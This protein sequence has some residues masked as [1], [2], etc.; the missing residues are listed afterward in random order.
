ML[1]FTAARAEGQAYCAAIRSLLALADAE[2]VQ[3]EIS[4][5]LAEAGYAED[6]AYFSKGAE[7]LNRVLDEAEMLTRGVR[8]SAEEFSSLLS[9][10]LKSLEISLIPQFTDAVFVGSLSESK[11]SAGKVL[12]AAALTSDVPASGAD[13]ALISDRDIDRLRTLKVEIQPKIR[14]VNARARE[15]AALALCSFTERLY[16]T[17]PLSQGGKECKKSEI[18][19]TVFAALAKKG[20]RAR[21]YVYA[22]QIRALGTGKRRRLRALS[23]VCRHRAGTRA[24]RTFAARRSIQAGRGGVLRAQRTV[25]RAEK[26]RRGRRFSFERADERGF[27]PQRRGSYV[28]RAARDLAHAHRGLFFPVLTRIFPSADC[29]SCRA[30]RARCGHWIRAISCTPSCSGRRSLSARSTANRRALRSP[31]GRRK[32][33]FPKRRFAI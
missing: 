20:R 30:L 13:T 12:F 33:C 6:S 25:F 22:R 7:S 14:E 3:E 4:K 10:S 19:D 15:S 23:L 17:Y 8:L 27:Y 1:S 2:K 31:A 16:L 29:A 18:F 9:E 11:K 28:P 21:R 32:N 26:Q 5:Q 24:Q